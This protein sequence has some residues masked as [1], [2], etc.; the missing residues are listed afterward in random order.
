MKDKFGEIRDN[1]MRYKSVTKFS[2]AMHKWAEAATFDTT[3]YDE[4]IVYD[5]MV[6]RKGCLLDLRTETLN[7]LHGVMLIEDLSE[8][9]LEFQGHVYQLAEEDHTPLVAE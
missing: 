1:G 6:A 8:A 5:S 3:G 7:E 9:T 2:Q 4:M